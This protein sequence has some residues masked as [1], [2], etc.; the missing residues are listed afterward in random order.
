[1]CPR[2]Q[3]YLI[4]DLGFQTLTHEGT[5]YH[6]INCGNYIDL[7]IIRNRQSTPKETPRVPKR[8]I[9][10]YDMGDD[11]YALAVRCSLLLDS[12]SLAGIL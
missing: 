7:T 12:G 5:A 2:C 9:S 6:C 3:G 11:T 10:K 1:M 8:R 4:R